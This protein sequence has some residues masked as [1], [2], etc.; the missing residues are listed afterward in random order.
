LA[1]SEENNVGGQVGEPLEGCQTYYIG[2]MW[3]FGNLN[4]NENTNSTEWTCNGASVDNKSQTDEVQG[5]IIFYAV[6]ERNNEDF[7]CSSW[8]PQD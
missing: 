4:W 7:L 8:T 3:C 5:D 1:D 6:Q 2:K